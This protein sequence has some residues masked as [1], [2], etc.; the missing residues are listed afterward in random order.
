MLKHLVCLLTTDTLSPRL[1]LI[2]RAIKADGWR[3]SVIAWDRTG[4]CTHEAPKIHDYV[5]VDDWKWVHVKAPMGSAKLL[6]S[7]PRF[8]REVFRIIAAF[9]ESRTETMYCATHFILLP[10][11]IFCKGRRIYDAAEMYILQFSRYLG[12]FWRLIS[13]LLYMMEGLMVARVDGV[14]TVDSRKGELER[15]YRRWN[16]NV[17]VLWNVPAL[18]DDPTGPQVKRVA[19]MMQG[20]R[21]VSY[22]GGGLREKGIRVALESVA[23][24]KKRYPNILYLFIGPIRD[25]PNDLMKF[26]ERLGIKDN[27]LFLGPM[28]YRAMLAYLRHA[29]IGL[30]LHQK[31]WIYPHVSSGNGRKFFTYMQAG[32]AII[33]PDFGEVGKAVVLADCGELLDSSNSRTVADAIVA[34]LRDEEKLK[35]YQFNARRA[36]EERFNWEN[37]REKLDVFFSR[38]SMEGSCE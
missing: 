27:V 7:L 31:E 35:R 36:F 32:L 8:Y 19:P 9:R 11:L 16:S 24:V 15:F 4:T 22:V 14:L 18:C 13:P 3:V 20:R 26:V 10:V 28:P 17:Q 5:Y 12:P 2:L 6:I 30:A 34:L 37:E 29:E 1:Q 25:D 38:L 33:G 23:E 21:I